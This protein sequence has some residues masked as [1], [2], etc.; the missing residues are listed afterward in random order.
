MDPSRKQKIVL[1]S[2]AVLQDHRVQMRG[3]RGSKKA[4]RGQAVESSIVL[5]DFNLWGGYKEPL[6]LLSYLGN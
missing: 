1:Y 6:G 5:Q 2:S 4:E 3:L